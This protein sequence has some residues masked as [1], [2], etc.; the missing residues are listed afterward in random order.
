MVFFKPAIGIALKDIAS[1]LVIVFSVIFALL[2]IYFGNLLTKTQVCALSF[3]ARGLPFFLD[4]PQISE[5]D[6]ESYVLNKFKRESESLE[7]K[8]T[9][10]PLIGGKAQKIELLTEQHDFEKDFFNTVVTGVANFEPSPESRDELSARTSKK[11]GKA[12]DEMRLERILR[13]LTVGTLLLFLI[14]FT[15]L[16]CLLWYSGLFNVVNSVGLLSFIVAYLI[17]WYIGYRLT[18]IFRFT[19][20]FERESATSPVDYIFAV[21]PKKVRVGDSHSLLL[22]LFFNESSRVE[23]RK[24][25]LQAEIQA[26]G[27]EF[28]DEA[29]QQYFSYDFSSGKAIWS[30]HFTNTGTHTINLIL[31]ELEAKPATK[32]M[33]RNVVFTQ[34]Y[35]ANV[36][37]PFRTSLQ[38]GLVLITSAI[39]AV[40]ALRALLP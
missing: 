34:K 33:T 4:L 30:C 38:P 2:A 23:H 5:F 7:R 31:S 9:A 6:F 20:I 12:A 1:S 10:L 13:R 14:I 40:T 35:D 16:L 32:N 24:E 3:H 29:K 25:L 17:F 36:I 22:Y 27:V 11:L 18:V 26:T 21:L 19:P 8:Q 28:D 37:S 15:V 39:S